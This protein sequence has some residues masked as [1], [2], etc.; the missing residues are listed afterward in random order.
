MN[1]KR[2]SAS[3]RNTRTAPRNA[4]GQ[5]YCNY[6][7]CQSAPSTFRRLS[8]W[9]KHMDKHERPYKCDVPGC[10]KV[11]GFTY[12]GGL[13]RHEREVHK[14]DASARAPIFCPYED[15]NRSSGNGFTR[16]ENLREHLRRRHL[17]TDDVSAGFSILVNPLVSLDFRANHLPAAVVDTCYDASLSETLSQANDKGS[18]HN[19]FEQLYREDRLK[20]R[21]IE[22]LERKVAVLQATIARST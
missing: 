20:G 17:H 9:N 8:D 13:L 7:G 4:D 19:E 22:E 16:Q 12:Y 18:L 10:N 3:S 21:R 5:I 11:Q 15:C 1:G 6:K 14:K 2:Q